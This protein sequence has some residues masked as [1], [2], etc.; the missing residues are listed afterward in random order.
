MTIT[1]LA[2]YLNCLSLLPTEQYEEISSKELASKIELKPTQVR[3]DFHHFGGFGQAGYRYK[4]N[5]LIIGLERI[6]GL[7][8][9]QKLIIV[10]MGHLGQALASYKNFEPLGLNLVAL[11]DVNPKLIG[12]SLRDVPIKD[13]DDL[14]AIVA[15]H[16]VTIAAITTPTSAAQNTANM[17]VAAGIKGIWNFSPVNLTTPP[18]V[19]VQN[20]HLSVGLMTLSYRL[21][22]LNKQNDGEQE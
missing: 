8:Q 15:K 22:T 18:D 9:Q 14:P 2:Q 7:D 19:I 13:I 10:G 17:L 4:V 11:F 20:E 21:K 12:L 16:N 3:Q 5:D 1:R 6:L